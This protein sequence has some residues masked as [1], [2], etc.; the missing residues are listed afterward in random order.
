MGEAADAFRESAA[1][2]PD[3]AISFAMLVASVAMKGQDADA[4][5]MLERHLAV[6]AASARTVV[7]IKSR[8]PYD[9]PFLHEV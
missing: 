7:Q 2:D 3:L 4:H 9:N 8:Q 6:P 5:Q 1:V